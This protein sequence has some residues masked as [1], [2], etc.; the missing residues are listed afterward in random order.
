MT[1]AEN[2]LIF[3]SRL[4]YVGFFM[5]PIENKLL[6]NKLNIFLALVEC[7]TEGGWEYKW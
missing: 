2:V 4:S 1:G 6:K 5:A 3:F 7:Y